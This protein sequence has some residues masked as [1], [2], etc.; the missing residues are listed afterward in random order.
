MG[1]RNHSRD[2]ERGRLSR[3]PR[4]PEDDVMAYDCAHTERELRLFTASNGV[5]H[6]RYQ[7]LECGG[8]LSSVRKSELTVDPASLP[9]W[10]SMLATRWWQARREQWAVENAAR[11]AAFQHKRWEASQEW[12]ARYHEHLAS[13]AWQQTR[14]AVL[15]RAEG[16][17]E[18]CG[19][20]AATQVHHLTYE[21]M[22]EEFL[23]ELVAICDACHRRLHPEVDDGVAFQFVNRS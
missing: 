17:C 5:T 4:L 23:F 11:E 16:I 12:W 8:H 6:A 18:G 2:M 14:R 9:A 13:P 19:R 7:C 15:R 21:H 20:V 22:G 1:D 10:D 3:R